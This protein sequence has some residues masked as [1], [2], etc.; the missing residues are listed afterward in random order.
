VIDSYDPPGGPEAML[1]L[2]PPDGPVAVVALPLFEEANRT[3]TF[4]VTIM[5]ALA[6]RGIASV[7]PDLPGTGDSLVATEDATLEA[8][9]TAFAS[10]AETTGAI[11]SVAIRGGALV[12]SSA[13]LT[14]R[15]H[16]APQTGTALMRELDRVRQ[17]GGGY[18]D[19]SVIEIAGNRLSRHLLGELGPA[20]VSDGRTRVVRLDNDAQAAARKVP[21][22]PLWRRAEPGNDP[23]LA[24]VLAD[25]IAE[26]V[27]ACAG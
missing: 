7:L 5:R 19:E 10:A 13:A 14:G 11:T 25:D 22:A 4:A 12:D 24:A 23:A 16:L 9:R 8:W 20:T 21:G 26:W 15:W 27:R 6:D 18:G 1:R 3:R 2:G 17:A